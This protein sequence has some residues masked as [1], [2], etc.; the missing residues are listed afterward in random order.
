MYQSQFLSPPPS[1]DNLG[2]PLLA[3]LSYKTC[4]CL[5]NIRLMRHLARGLVLVSGVSSGQEK[6]NRMIY[7][8]LIC[9]EY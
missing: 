5:Q 4:S 6:S 9:K 8:L 3:L 7:E 2:L 1:S